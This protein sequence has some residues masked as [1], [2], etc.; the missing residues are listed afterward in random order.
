MVWGLRQDVLIFGL[1]DRA[2]PSEIILLLVYD[3]ILLTFKF[4]T[5]RGAY[6]QVN[7]LLYT[8]T[9]YL[10]RVRIRRNGV[11]GKNVL[12]CRSL[13]LLTFLYYYNIVHDASHYTLYNIL[14]TIIKCTLQQYGD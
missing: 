9:L 14:R 5:D 11:A 2:W 1:Q 7:I 8:R 10:L 4:A 12:W 3:G 6:G 13:L